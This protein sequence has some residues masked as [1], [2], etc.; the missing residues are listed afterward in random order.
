MTTVRVEVKPELLRWARER[1]GFALTDL[2]GRFP[3]L[4]E[5]E[6]DAA[7]PTLTQ[8]ESFAKA[9]HTPVGYLFLPE[10]PVEQVPIPDFRTVGN[11]HI[12]HPTPDLLDTLYMCQQ[13]QE[14]FRGFERSMG[15]EPLPFVGSAHNSDDVEATGAKLRAALGFDLEERR[16]LPTWTDALRR[17]IEQ[18]DGLGILVMCSGVVM[19]NNHRRLNPDEFRGFALADN[20]APLVFINGADTKAAQ[21]FTLA[22]ELAHIWLGQSALSDGQAAWIPDNATEGWCNRVAAELLVPLALLR[23][24]YRHGADLFDEAERLARRFKVSKLV[25]LRRIYDLGGLSRDD[26]WRAYEVELEFLRNIAK[27]SGG[28]F[29]LTQAAQ[30]SKRFARALFISTM[31]GRSTFTEAFRLLGFKK[32]DTFRE[33]GHSLG[34]GL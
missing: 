33:L 34:V 1:A 17:F 8:L 9:T 10:P 24:E 15:G 29:Y 20:L 2:A 23:G 21:M 16:K 31:E 5:W 28:N 11:V 19:N 25:I 13:R 4:Q 7:R 6:A 27:G 14:W 32:M 3:K 12:G 18:A 30:V 22:H 26:Y